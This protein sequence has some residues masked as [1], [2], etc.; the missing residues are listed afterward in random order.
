MV[1][2]EL[3]PDIAS[4]TGRRHELA[5]LGRVLAATDQAKPV[6]IAAI[7]GPGGIG[8][9]ALAIHAAHRMAERFPDG[10]LLYVHLQGATSGL[11]PLDPLEALGRMLRSLGLASA[12]IPAG[13][14]EAA[15]RFRSPKC[16]LGVH[17]HG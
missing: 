2:R 12:Q 11:S 7:H 17:P 13:L 1:P 5:R 14:D 15:V 4:F 16:F 9:S 10:Q 3:P 6:A 8:K